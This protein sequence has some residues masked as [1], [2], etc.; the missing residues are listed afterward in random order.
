MSRAWS[1]LTQVVTWLV[2]LAAVAVL[3]GAVLLPRVTGATPYTIMTGSMAPTY[4]PGTLVIV[5]PVPF[6]DIRVGDVVTFQLES[7]EAAVATHR[8][9]G[10]TVSLDGERRLVTRGDANGADDPEPVREVQVRGRVWYAVPYL[11][12]VNQLLTGGRRQLVMTV[13]VTFLLLY[14][15]YMFTSAARDRR[16]RRAPQSETPSDTAERGA[17]VG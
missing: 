12:R 4:P 2:I 1:W 17:T 10:S 11:G 14:S 16:R 8:V 9:V 3:G 13:V 6:E 5:R 15:A 7:G